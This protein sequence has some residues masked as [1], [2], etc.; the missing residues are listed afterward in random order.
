LVSSNFAN[1]YGL[2]VGDRVR[3]QT[4]TEAFDRPIAGVIE[5]YT[6]EKGSIFLDRGMYKRYW[7]DPSID[8][9]NVN[10]AP[11]IDRA[12]FKNELQRALKGQQRAFIYT[13][14]E[15]RAW[16]LKLLDQFFAMMYMQMLVAIF[17]AALGIVNA[18]I[19]STAERKR[20][21]GVIR[22]IGG[23]RGQ[24][25]KMILLEAVVIG[26]IGI[27]TAAIAGVFSAYF[28]TRT[29]AAMIGGYTIPFVFPARII[30]FASPI[31][32]VIA[33]LSAWWPARRA[34]NMKVVE[35]IGY[36]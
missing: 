6:S 19:I 22:A 11:G 9:I 7:N 10:L 27:V 24:L 15:W 14:E 20:E 4:P 17:A 2:W 23:L 33:L 31:V 13:R 35:A 32:L 21:L 25:R 1:R 18:L 29:A 26:V 12:A 16:V 3:L 34:V 30:L 36:E 5:D 8:I 28:L